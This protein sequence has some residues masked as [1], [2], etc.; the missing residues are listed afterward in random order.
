MVLWATETTEGGTMSDGNSSGRERQQTL[1]QQYEVPTDAL[2][3]RH[4]YCHEPGCDRAPEDSELV[5]AR[6]TR[7]RALKGCPD[8]DPRGP[9]PA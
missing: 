6:E 4:R 7:L 9:D 2:M 5:T 3:Q 8:C 1:D